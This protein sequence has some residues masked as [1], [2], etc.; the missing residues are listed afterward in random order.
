MSW[1]SSLPFEQSYITLP[2][3]VGFQLANPS[4]LYS[5]VASLVILPTFIS[6]RSLRLLIRSCLFFPHSEGGSSFS[7]ERELMKFEVSSWRS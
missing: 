6:P 7:S 1:P 4:P 5:S 3:P 2:R